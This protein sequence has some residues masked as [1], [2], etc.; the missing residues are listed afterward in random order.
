MQDSRK[1]R[2]TREALKSA[3]VELL[4]TQPLSK[5][6][7]ARLCRQADLSRGT[8]YLHYSTPEELFADLIE[9]QIG[10]FLSVLEA[11]KETGQRVPDLANAILPLL[12]DNPAMAN[13]LIQNSSSVFDRVFAAKRMYFEQ[14]CREKYPHLSD[15]EVHYIRTFKEAGVAHLIRQWVS[16]GMKESP[17]QIADL[18]SELL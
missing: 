10:G 12:A 18:L 5:V 15:T 17:D 8:F 1:T 2:Y 4:Q 13:A 6:S 7:V 16:G 9:D 11:Q 14:R 3:L